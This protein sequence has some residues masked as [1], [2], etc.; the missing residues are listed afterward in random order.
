M[1]KFLVIS[2]ALLGFAI[3]AWSC[4]YG[5]YDGHNNYMFSVFRREAMQGP[6]SENQLNQFWKDYTNGEASTFEWGKEIIIESAK[7]KGDQE[8]LDYLTQL[9]RYVDISRDL[10]DS[11]NYPTKAELQQRKTDLNT[12]LQKASAYKGKRLQGQ[13]NLLRM[14]ANMVLGDH[15]SNINFWNQ[16]A[17]KLPQ[18]IYK[19]MM[20]SIYAGALLH[21]GKQREAFDIYAKNG[22][23]V[24]IKWAMRKY[25]NLAGIQRIYEESPNSPCMPF[26]IQD[27]VN[28]T[29]ETLDCSSPEYCEEW[30]QQLDARL[31][32]RQEADRFIDY[33]NKVIK[34]G[35]TNDPALWQAAIGELQYLNGQY[36]E[37]YAS[38]DKAVGMKGTARMLDNAR[39]IRMVASVKSH[40]LD[41]KYTQWMAG[42]MKW[43]I[44]KIREETATTPDTDRSYTGVYNHYLDILDRLI[45]QE[46][47][48]KYV[49]NGRPDMAAALKGLLNEPEVLIGKKIEHMEETTWNGNY[50]SEYFSTLDLMSA[51]QTIDYLRFLQDNK[52]DELERLVK[53]YLDYDVN[54]FNDLIGT[55]FLAEN[56]FDKAIP[57]LQKVPLSFMEGQ[58]ISCYLATRDWHKSKWLVNQR[59]SMFDISEGP[60]TGKLTNNPKLEFCKEMIDL[61]KRY[62]SADKKTRPQV[63]YDLANN[64]YQA[65]YLGDCWCL[66]Q[67]GS[68]VS[69]TARV[70][71]PDFVEFAIKYLNESKAGS[72]LK[73]QENSLFGLA[74]IPYGE[75]CTTTWDWDDTTNEYKKIINRN[76]RQFNALRELNSFVNSHRG[77]VSSKISRCDV[78]LQFRK[79]I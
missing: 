37:A 34:S 62:Q 75:W 79:A 25:R 39:A 71:R 36:V 77:E 53:S 22:D 32:Q 26:L 73:L 45:Y 3:D 9:I 57:Y 46:L 55:K 38:L 56:Q 54:F 69:D 20:E 21:T 63:A 47:A 66:T 43:L 78:L 60:H 6:V 70:D 7:K 15:A 65:S 68:S 8:M 64:Y 1:R 27:F 33:A 41:S 59:E 61:Q 72:N 23:L 52:G 13:W 17:S 35:K 19:T 14:R 67:Y 18:S 30:L 44:G 28:N 48:P 10:Q 31:I 74:F 12:M 2:L 29:Q 16:T 4:G 51:D 5:F 50:N 76:S 11:W 49:A 40:A 58:N 24:S 42:E